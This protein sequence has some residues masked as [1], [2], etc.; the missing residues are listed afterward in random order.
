MGTMLFSD[1]SNT[2]LHSDTKLLQ[3]QFPENYF[4]IFLMAFAPSDIF[5]KD[6]HVQGICNFGKCF[7][8]SHF[9]VS[10]NF[11]SDG[12]LACNKRLRTELSEMRNVNYH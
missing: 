3:K 2:I 5:A 7:I 4:R 1:P 8:Q 11:V 6:R 9:F 10:N 12:N